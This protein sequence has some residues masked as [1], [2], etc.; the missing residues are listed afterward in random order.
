MT[1][2][3]I[4]IIGGG[5]AG[6]KCAKALRKKLPRDSHEIVI[7]NRENH[8]VFHPLLPEVVG[9]SINPM[10]VAVSLRQML[11]SVRCRTEEVEK[12]DL[13]NSHVEY[14]SE[15]GELH[16]ISY[17]HLVIACGSVIN[18]GEVP[19]MADHAFPMKTIGDAIA[20]RVH[21]MQQLEM[22]EVCDDPERKHRHL[23]FIVLGG[24]F[25]GVEVAGEINDLVRGA[26]RFF[27]NTSSDQI[28]VT[29]IHSRDQLLQEISPKLRDFVR[30]K[31]EKADIKVLLHNRVEFVTPEG[32]GLND[33]RMLRG[34]TVVCT[35]G[36]T[37]PPVVKRLEIPK[38]RGRI[39]TEDDMRVCGFN[40]AWAIGDCAHIIN[41]HDDKASPP[42]GQFAERQGA[43]VAENIVRV[44][45]GYETRPFYFRPLGQLCSIG[46][47]RA[48]AELFGMRVSGFLAWFLWRGIYLFKLPSWSRRIEVGFDWALELFFP[49]DLAHPKANQTQRISRCHYHSGDFVF[50]QGEPAT[51][52]Y[53]IEKGE[54]E[55]LRYNGDNDSIETLAVLGPGDFF[56]EM[57][58]IDNRPHSASVR[59]REPLE[60][61]VMG[62][63][64]FT[65]ISNSLS[66]LHNI[67]ADSAKRR[68]ATSL[69]Q[70]MP[71]AR[72]VLES[73]PLLSFL[74][75]LGKHL[76]LESTLEQAI[77][78]FEDG[79]EFCCIVDEND[80]LKGIL[81]R[82]DLL[83][84]FEVELCRDT[85]VRD[86][87]VRD[88][89]AVTSTD[90]S[91]LA[92]ATMRDHGLKWLPVIDS[93][94]RR[95][96]L[97]Y[98]RAE[99]ML[100]GILHRIIRESKFESQTKSDEAIQLTMNDSSK[101]PIP[102]VPA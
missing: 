74:N 98:V 78:L 65:Q 48:V 22:A 61:V 26:N 27:P 2:S 13:G 17:D 91:L 31:M 101:L 56:G 85:K 37:M 44:L 68:S 79:F 64:V 62:R 86:F 23:S 19:G 88:P 29:I 49:R 28:T 72:E 24:G 100:Y 6:V 38:E 46:G 69:W 40:N 70:R 25:S 80:C 77:K 87:M 75:P 36:N 99:K 59:A 45:K 21:V 95:K 93:R 14:E 39:I 33:S 11:P 83:R 5:F 60:V 15:N 52:F 63:K 34:A 9:A 30:G 96:V 55:V 102:E 90:S 42:T 66:S 73:Q 47:H 92:A 10:D 4:L 18:I 51:N 67:I 58:L 97:G 8:M 82:T 71:L 43:Q 12:I 84:A 35:I 20:L 3:R 57:A 1:K 50:R 53:I 94:E 7:F 16:R 41:S 89:L 32:V 76:S 81:T 54:V